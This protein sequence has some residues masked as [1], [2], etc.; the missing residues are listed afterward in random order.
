MVSAS[1][2]ESE[3][4]LA[5]AVSDWMRSDGWRTY[6]EVPLG[7]GR[8]DILGV[9]GPL[10][11]AVETKLR[12]S[13][14]LVEQAMA[15]REGVHAALVAIPWGPKLGAFKKVLRILG[16]GLITARSG[17]DLEVA[18]WP[19]FRRQVDTRRLVAQLVPEQEAQVA[20][21]SAGSYWTPFKTCARGL[22][23]MMAQH[24]RRSLAEVA[25]DEAL[26]EY[27]GNQGASQLRRWVLWAVERGL[28]PGCSVETTGK[29]RVVVFER[30]KITAADVRN[31]QLDAYRLAP[32]QAP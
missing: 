22:V 14:N 12:A 9:R 27:K 3:A 7:A 20:G 32:L 17:T 26:I 13:F 6:Q 23:Y 4:V 15:R 16:L 24:G 21:L 19:E 31:L 11:W 25:A 28:I 5:Q 1:K 29:A 8:I 2:F 18:V 10:V 30:S